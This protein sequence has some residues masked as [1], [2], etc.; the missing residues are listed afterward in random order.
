MKNLIIIFTLVSITCLA[1]KSQVK[2]KEHNIGTTLIIP[3]DGAIISKGTMIVGDTFK[4]KLSK[5]NMETLQSLQKRAY[6]LHKAIE[7]YARQLQIIDSAYMT[8]IKQ[9]LWEEGLD[10]E[11]GIW[12]IASGKL[13]YLP[14]KR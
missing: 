6:G 4:I 10:P 3:V 9:K 5:F 7:P 2:I 12:T 8:V 1:Q 13:L 11:N 14:N